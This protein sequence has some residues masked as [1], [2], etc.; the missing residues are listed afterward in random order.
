M[1]FVEG[2]DAWDDIKCIGNNAF[3]GTIVRRVTVPAKLPDAFADIF[4][5]SIVA[6]VSLTS[7]T[8]T[9]PVSFLED[10]QSVETL[11]MYAVTEIGSSAFEGCESLNNINVGEHL[12]VLGD[13][14]FS[15]V[16]QIISHTYAGEVGDDW[17]EFVRIVQIPRQLHRITILIF[18]HR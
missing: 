4:D 11:T 10:C 5:C 17:V 1:L 13:K 8:S 14:A 12:E 3:H 15:G 7:S 18:Q 16:Q 6:E 9:I 2:G